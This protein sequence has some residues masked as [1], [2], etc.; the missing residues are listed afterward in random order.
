[1]SVRFMSH[2]IEYVK[3]V[4][5]A[6][7][8]ILN[9]EL[10]ITAV[11]DMLYYFPYRYIDRSQ[12]HKISEIHEEGVYVQLTGRIL[13]MQ[14]HGDK[15]KTRLTVL[16]GDQTGSIELVWFQ[17]VRW[18]TEKLATGQEYVVFGRTGSFGN[19]FT[20]PHPEMELLSE[21][22]ASP[23]D[24]FQPLYNTTEKMK[25]KGLDSR[26]MARVMKNI[27][28]HPQ[29]RLADSFPTRGSSDHRKSVV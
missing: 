20:L 9:K 16:L 21:Y 26:G 27:M 10:N 14:T 1:M 11:G 7:A 17:G 19:R 5:P 23:R 22:K 24:K 6:R 15:R 3:G 8:D 12:F 18:I 25:T 28:Q 2:P 13:G 4:G 29:Y